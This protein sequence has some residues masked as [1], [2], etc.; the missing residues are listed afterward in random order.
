MAKFLSLGFLLSL[1]IFCNPFPS[2]KKVNLNVLLLDDAKLRSTQISNVSYWIKL[3]IND[4]EEFAGTTI[5]QFDLFK[6]NSPLRVDFHKGKIL[7]ISING[8]KK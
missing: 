1:Q 7:E 5:I 6:T 4:K 3:D 8:K 2:E